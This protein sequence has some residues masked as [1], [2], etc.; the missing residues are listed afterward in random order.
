MIPM[1]LRLIMH[2]AVPHATLPSVVIYERRGA[3]SITS[4]IYAEIHQIINRQSI[5]LHNAELAPY[6]QVFME[7]EM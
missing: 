3:F 6:S 1:P 5:H 7:Q 2:G 4:C